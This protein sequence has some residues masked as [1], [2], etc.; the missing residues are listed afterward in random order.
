MFMIIISL[1]IPPWPP[2][3]LGSAPDEDLVPP[4]VG[5]LGGGVGGQHQLPQ[6]HRVSQARVS[7][8]LKI[9]HWKTKTREIYFP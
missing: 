6:G 5:H 8:H 2:V 4:P 3:S 7:D 9:F 1:D